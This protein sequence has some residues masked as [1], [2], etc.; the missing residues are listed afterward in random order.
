MADGPIDYDGKMRADNRKLK[1]A[2]KTLWEDVNY[3]QKFCLRSVCTENT[4]ILVKATLGLK[5]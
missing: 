3:H 5:P 1:L 2:L 4:E